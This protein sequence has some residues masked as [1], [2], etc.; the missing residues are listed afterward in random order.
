MSGAADRVDDV[1][2]VDFEEQLRLQERLLPAQIDHARAGST[3]YAERLGRDPVRTFD[4]LAGLPFVRKPE[5][6]EAQA[7]DPPLGALAAVPLDEVARLH[8]TSGTT[9]TPLLIGFTAGDLER[10]TRAGSRA[11]RA[12]GVRERH[13]ILHCLNYAFYVGGIADHMS[14][15]ATGATVVPV[16]LGQSERLLDLFSILRPN[17]MF[18]ITSYSHHLAEVA[19]R[20]GLEPVEMG[21]ELIVTGGEPGGDVPEIRAR[22][23]ETWNARVADTY[24]LGEVWPTLAG[25]CNLRDGLHLTAPDLLATELLDPATERPL[26]WRSGAVGE[27]VYTHLDREASPLVRYR[28]GDMAEILSV[29]C[30]CGRRTPRFRLVGRVDDMFIVRG[31]N[32]FP[33]A[34]ESVLSRTVRG[35]RAFAV[36]L[37][38]PSPTPPVT[39][40]VEAEAPFDPAPV[41][42]ALRDALQTQ[43]R[44]VGVAL[45]TIELGEQKSKRVFREYEGEQPAWMA[46]QR[47]RSHP[48][49]VQRLVSG[50]QAEKPLD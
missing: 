37:D 8:V 17:A 2:R 32:V 20:C 14:V 9:G 50:D 24:G 34:I 26:D 23:E 29:A 45:R 31:V 28:S 16:G 38:A 30:E 7:Q 49:E 21:L 1:E 22:I 35:L 5:L 39:V 11:F 12:A 46:S 44:A 19:R 36:C 47:G 41:E 4:D 42:R 6:R 40:Y 18:A 48:G 25:H 15:E 13:T 3:F 10:S 33:S 27:L 43:F